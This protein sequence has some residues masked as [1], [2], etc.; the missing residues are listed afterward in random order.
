MQPMKSDC[1]WTATWVFWGALTALRLAAAAE[2]FTVATYNLE[3]YVLSATETRSVKPE[4][5][6]AKIHESIQALRP[7]VLAVQEI[8]PPTDLL[9]LQTALKGRGL[10]YAHWEHV[11]G[12]D[13][14]IYVAVLS[15]FPIVARRSH[16]N[17][18][19]LLRGRRFHSSR[20]FAEVDL[21]VNRGY[22]FTLL[23]AHLK[24]KRAV[25]SADE[26][27]LREQEAALLR[28]KIDALLARHPQANLAVVGDLNDTQDSTTIRT[29]IG[30]GRTALVDTRPAERNGDDQ[31]HPNPRYAPRNVT[32]TH[33]Y[34]KADTYQR[35][36]YIL[37][38]P[39]LARE[40]QP[41]GTYVL[42]LPNWGVGSDHRPLLATF[43]ARDP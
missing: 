38:S 34:G 36:D 40:W 21:E 12:W 9:A 39:G 30:R 22:R 3:N 29:V 23:V 32:W 6:R 25:G 24:S 16:T 15:R 20:G 11:S 37:L 26:A 42:A 35:V 41:E 14:N 43:Q 8:G 27:E 19:F 17:E 7:D 1:G 10:D 4:P 2:T 5:A 31:P 13:T 28:R 33:H 18:S